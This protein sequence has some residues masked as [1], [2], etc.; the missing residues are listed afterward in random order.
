[1]IYIIKKKISKKLE[2]FKQ[3]YSY[4]R[5]YEGD[6]PVVYLNVAHRTKVRTYLNLFFR[7]KAVYKEP[8]V[9]QFSVVRML[10]LAKWFKQLDY[11][12]FA[13]PF[14]KL[15]KL[16]TF[17]HHK[18]AD[19]VV[20]YKYK[21]VYTT[22]DYQ[23][24]VLPYI[25][26]P[27][28]YLVTQT[29]FSSK[30]IGIIL[31]GN[32]EEKIYNTT[33]IP[34]NFKLL[35]RW[36]IYQEVIQHKSVLSISGKELMEDLDS[37]KFS[38]K[39]VAMRWQSG[40][41]PNQK[42]R[43]YLTA[44]DFIFCAPG[45]TMPMCHNVLEAMSVGVIPILNYPHWLNPSLQDDFN[46]LVYQSISDIKLIVD[47]ALSLSQELKNEMAKNV[48]DYYNAYYGEYL[49]DENKNTELI[50]LNENIKDLI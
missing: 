40:A 20:N 4:V 15:N 38:D 37:K 9:I 2:E 25:M 47:K 31:S 3:Y 5:F 1:M 36:D 29:D 34:D 24:N 50:V 21:K 13:K 18:S 27:F 35:N 10:L 39:L 8:I 43:Y 49:F 32:F 7:I 44:A 23:K 26:H 14:S 28:N 46:C 19:F 6:Q 48:L 11:I 41:I 22:S 16:K 17:S 12:Y 42:W 45:M 30:K 33:L